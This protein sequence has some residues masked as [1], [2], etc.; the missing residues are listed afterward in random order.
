MKSRV[1]ANKILNQVLSQHCSLTDAF[2]EYIPNNVDPRDIG[3]VKECCFGVLR[4]FHQLSSIKSL[5]LNSPLKKKDGDIDSLILLGLFQ[6]LYTKVPDHAAVSETVSVCKDLKKEWATRLVNKCLRRFIKEKEALLLSLKES[7]EAYLSHPVWF[8]KRVKEAWPNHWESILVS[9]N[10]KPPLWLRV[11]CQKTSQTDYLALLK[12]NDIEA[13]ASNDVPSG[14]LLQKAI[15]TQHIPQFKEGLSSVQDIAGQ[16]AAN[17]LDLKKGQRV[18]DA[19]AAPGS[20]TCHI[21][22]L[23][24]ELSKLVIV[25]KSAKRFPMVKENIMRLGLDYRNTQLILADVTHTKQWWD[26]S[27]FDR[28]LLDVPCSAMGI[29]RRHPDIKVLRQ[30]DDIDHISQVQMQMLIALWRLLKKKG[31]LLYSTCSIL[32]EENEQIVSSFLAHNDDVKI[33]K[34]DLPIGQKQKYGVQLFPEERGSDGFYYAL[35]RKN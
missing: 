2:S 18:L 7:E 23:Q 22:E 5:L 3:F 30:S 31:K 11:N 35:L 29:I 25:D 28:I 8:I 27:E 20:K 33:E 32:P 17:L 4:W 9:N 10:Q 24:P 26:G 21:L 13:V 19:C 16:F 1:A 6:L 14:I 34:I 15:S 12:Q